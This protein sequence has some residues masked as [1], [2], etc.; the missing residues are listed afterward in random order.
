MGAQNSIVEYM[1]VEESQM[2]ITSWTYLKRNLHTCGITLFLTFFGEFPEN[3]KY[4][5]DIVDQKDHVKTD[6]YLV[7]HCIKVMRAIGRGVDCI[8]SQEDFQKYIIEH[9]SIHLEKKITKKTY[10][11]FIG[12]FS[13]MLSQELG[14]RYSNDIGQAW[15]KF[16]RYLFYGSLEYT[17]KLLKD[18]PGSSMV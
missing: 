16:L 18:L 10:E 3:T 9:A 12:A 1:N 14:P 7:N 2:I 15:E 8:K 17:R 4:F 13:N 11:E 5:K 6:Q